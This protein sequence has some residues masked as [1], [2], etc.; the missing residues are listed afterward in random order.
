[1]LSQRP[2]IA[3]RQRPALKRNAT[4]YTG[5]TTSSRLI[6]R[7]QPQLRRCFKEHLRRLFRPIAR[8]WR[9]NVTWTPTGTAGADDSFIIDDMQLEIVRDASSVA[10]PY[11][12]IPRSVSGRPQPSDFYHLL[13]C[14][15]RLRTLSL[16]ASVSRQ[17]L[18][19]MFFLSRR[20][21]ALVVTA[22]TVVRV[23]HFSI[24]S[25]TP[26]SLWPCTGLTFL[27]ASFNGGSVQCDI[28]IWSNAGTGDQYIE[29]NN[30]SW[31]D[32]LHGR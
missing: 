26:G 23:G 5:E 9:F 11:R 21:P 16:W 10:T 6:V 1:M 3:E 14:Q 24:S 20:R 31:S 32:L 4:P 15:R 28:R 17:R 30:A 27:S 18:V 29:F 2:S 7:R 25:G 13:I 12:Y 19:I 22:V 8:R